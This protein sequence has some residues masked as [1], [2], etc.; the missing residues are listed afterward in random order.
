MNNF[1]D[2]SV[3]GGM[4]VFAMLLLGLLAASLIKKSIKKLQESLI[5]TSVLAGFVLLVV[6]GVYMTLTG[7]SMFD[8]D[9]MGG[10]GFSILE[11]ITYHALALG[12][13][14]STFESSGEKATKQRQA[15][16]FNTGVTTVST[17]LVQAI[18]GL[19]L[20][21][22]ISKIFTDIFPAAGMILPFGFG[23][24]TGQAMNYGNIYET[25]YGFVGG[26]SFGL[27]IAT[28]GFLS[29][30]LGGV[31][32]LSWLKRKNNITKRAARTMKTVSNRSAKQDEIPLYES[33]DT[34]GVQL[35]F[36]LG[37]Y[38]ITYGIIFL[39]G[40]LIPGLKSIVYGF[41]FLIGVLVATGVKKLLSVLEEKK[42]L[43]KNYVNDFLMIRLRNVFYDVMV[44]AGIAAI[45][46]S[47][48]KGYVGVL[49]VICV[50]GA[51]L[52]FAYN[53]LVSRILFKDYQDE[54]LVAMYGMLTGTAS[55]GIVLL[56]ELDP[57]FETPVSDNLVY[58]N[59]PAIIF[60]LPLML[61]AAQAPENPVGTL[62]IAVAFFAVL[63]IILFRSK[64]AGLFKKK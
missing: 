7:N 13:I 15:E 62:L 50:I 9:F 16:I 33:M 30:S 12:F 18:T 6:S 42:I 24:G 1:W 11:T 40:E 39:L 29:A 20:T 23:Q 35:A 2:I 41:N 58:Q 10:D 32:Y 27:A 51:I 54:Q 47:T 59:F 19:G 57:E 22:V 36:I 28:L 26:K 63:N 44:V 8:T 31:L 55:T 5:P 45:R 37:S 49:I 43:K 34:L 17:Y 53:W 38:M 60:G 52:S 14:A 46:V 4:N 64:I 48:M 21:I 3:W 25:D 61:I 56:R